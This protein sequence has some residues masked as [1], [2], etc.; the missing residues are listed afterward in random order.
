MSAAPSDD[1]RSEA[2]E[3]GRQVCWLRRERGW[4]G[5][6]GAGGEA[7]GVMCNVAFVGYTGTQDVSQHPPSS[8]THFFLCKRFEQLFFLLQLVPC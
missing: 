4:V 1:V 2:A 5:V 6:L 3:R 7:A 8:P